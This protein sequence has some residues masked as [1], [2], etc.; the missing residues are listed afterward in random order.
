MIV[1]E[2]EPNTRCSKCKKVVA[3]GK[4]YTDWQ[5][6]GCRERKW[7][8]CLCMDCLLKAGHRCEPYLG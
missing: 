7:S 8:V 1:N 2:L 3:V 4:V 6:Q 5:N